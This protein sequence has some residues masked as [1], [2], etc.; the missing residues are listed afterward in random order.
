[1]PQQQQ[2]QND[3]NNNKSFTKHRPHNNKIHLANENNNTQTNIRCILSLS[4]ALLN[5]KKI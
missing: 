5:N 4:K 2:Q 3:N 1:M